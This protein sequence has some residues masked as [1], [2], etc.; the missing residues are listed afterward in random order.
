MLRFGHSCL[1]IRISIHPFIYLSTFIFSQLS[2]YSSIYLSIYLHIICIYP[3]N[4]QF[5]HLFNLSI[6]PS[7]QI[8]IYHSSNYPLSSYLPIYQYIYQSIFLIEW[9]SIQ[10]PINLS[11]RSSIH[12]FYYLPI[13]SAKYSTIMYP[14]L[15]I[16][17]IYLY[18]CLS[19]Y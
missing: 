16:F 7:I 4:F 17:F 6:H 8:S 1:F 15:T 9:L 5:I 14:Y 3:S 19:I 12:P 10:V 11:I 2:I 18:V 13:Y